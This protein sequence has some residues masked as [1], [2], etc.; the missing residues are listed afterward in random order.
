MTDDVAKI[1]RGLTKAQRRFVLT[2]SSRFAFDHR[3]KWH[4]FSITTARILFE[5]GLIKRCETLAYPTDLGLAVRAYLIA[6][7]GEG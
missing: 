3:G 4:C 2:D 7:Q 6:Q 1:A 5:Q